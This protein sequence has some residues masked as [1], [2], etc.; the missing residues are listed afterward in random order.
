MH[1]RNLNFST[2][3][4]HV[5]LIAAA[6]Y[7]Y[8]GY[9][10]YSEAT[11]GQIQHECVEAMPLPRTRTDIGLDEQVR[12]WLDLDTWSDEDTHDG[13]VESDTIGSIVWTVASGG[14][15][16]APTTGASTTYDATGTVGQSVI[17]AV[18]MDSGGAFLDQ[19]VRRQLQVNKLAPTH[20]VVS[21]ISDNPAQGA[22]PPTQIG[23]FSKFKV[24]IFPTN[25]SFA[26]TKF[27]EVIAVSPV[28]W[29]DGTAENVPGATIPYTVRTINNEVNI[30]TD[31]VAASKRPIGR[32]H[33][34]VSYV[35]FNWTRAVANEYLWRG[36][37]TNFENVTFT[38]YYRGVDQKACASTSA[39]NT[40][41][42]GWMGPY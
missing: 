16:V 22:N 11:I 2:F 24:Q 21:W 36:N 25:V 40:A 14:G 38:F 29:P 33:N 9:G 34:G 32:I 7:C 18:V 8:A 20:S 13:Q 41:T 3:L 28:A 35:N 1:K 27:H 23:C 4:V 6:S 12:C 42:G 15:V 10:Q 30:T 5:F 39:N 26:M 37:W 17:E 19:P 31:D